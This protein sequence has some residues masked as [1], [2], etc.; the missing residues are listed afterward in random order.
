MRA[1]TV[2]LLNQRAGEAATKGEAEGMGSGAI[3]LPAS[4]E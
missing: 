3:V 1:G 4:R 2:L